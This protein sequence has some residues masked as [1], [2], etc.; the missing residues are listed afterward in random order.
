MYSVSEDHLPLVNDCM[1]EL[2]LIALMQPEWLRLMPMEPTNETHYARRPLIME[3]MLWLIR[4]HL[5]DLS[6]VLFD[7]DCYLFV[8]AKK[9]N[10]NHYN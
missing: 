1:V 5:V 4:L 3:L 9:K 2:G 8:A 7:V 6:S 10:H